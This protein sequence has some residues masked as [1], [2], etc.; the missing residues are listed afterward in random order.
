MQPLRKPIVLSLLNST[1]LTDSEI[2]LYDDQGF[3]LALNDDFDRENGNFLSL[4]DLEPLRAGT[5]YVGVGGYNYFFL[6]GYDTPALNGGTT[7]GD[8]TLDYPGGSQSGFADTGIISWYRFD[9]GLPV[10]DLT[11]FSLDQSTGDGDPELGC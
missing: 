10:I 11:A 8:F 3:A 5:Y 7:I 4:L 1:T 2:A 9:V 6:T